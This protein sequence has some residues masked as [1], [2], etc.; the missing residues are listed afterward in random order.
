MPTLWYSAPS[1]Q[2]VQDP[3]IEQ[4]IECMREEYDG[5]WGPYSPVGV[6][7]WQHMS[8]SQSGQLLFVRHPDRGW[9]FEC[10]DFVTYDSAADDGKWVHH[11]GCG[12]PMYYRAAC[13]VPQVVAEQVVTDYVA[14]GGCSR[15]TSW[16]RQS[17]IQSR[18]SLEQRRELRSRKKKQ[19]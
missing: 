14:T 15:A 9:Y 13:F 18:L 1:G 3:T 8:Q 5:N 2:R 11:W 10:N 7:E 6:L 16:A 4:M 12:E 19:D 17:E